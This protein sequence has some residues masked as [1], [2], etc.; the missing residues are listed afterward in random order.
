MT[1][2][3]A[4]KLEN[5][6]A[7]EKALKIIYAVFRVT[8]L[9][10]LMIIF[11]PPL[12]PARI[13]T[14]ITK[15][16]SLFTTTFSYN[17]ITDTLGRS[18]KLN[19]I[20]INTI[21][22]LMVSCAIIL[23]GVIAICAG[24]CLSLGNKT[25]KIKG[26]WFPIVGSILILAGLCGIY[27]SYIRVKNGIRPDKVP[28]NLSYS[29]Y[30]FIA[31][32][33]FNFILSITIRAL[34]RQDKKKQPFKIEQKY[35]LFLMFLPILILTF[36]FCYL[37]LY[38]WRYAFFD[39]TVGSDLTWK[40]F[41][42]F[43]WFTF[44]FK[45]KETF[46]DLLRVLRNTLIMSGL[47]ILTNWLPIAFAV[48]LVEIP[49]VKLKKTIQ[50]LTTLPYFIS[51]VL[52]YAFALALF[53]TDGLLNNMLSKITGTTHNTNYLQGDSWIWLKMLLWGTWKGIGWSAIVYIASLSSIDQQMYEA[54]DLDGA[55]RF[56]KINYITIP[57]LM[58]TY[59][60]LLMLQIAGMLSNGLDQY[61]VFGNA[62]NMDKIEV[63]D[64]YVY[65]LGF[66]KNNNM[67][68]I[69]TLVSMAKS[70]VSVILLF[71][72]NGASKLIRGE[73]IV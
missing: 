45:N 50:T 25:A 52:I 35:T 39:Y 2:T 7:K 64:L 57:M 29:Y 27:F 14:E 53:S 55:K 10:T 16:A 73:T 71:L 20:S 33:A 22:I 54:A 62:F 8:A 12:N 66:G 56:Q 34:L 43:Y 19:Y 23:I 5:L 72:A 15:H 32:A 40:N 30:L 49:S 69:S 1:D 60:V 37:P 13:T 42:G 4:L 21:Y 18:I 31:V 17:T 36:V 63:L 3:T 9:I 47:G 65:D 44:L 70:I 59:F 11:F 28:P 58:P 46:N 38:G 68:P 6:T 26:S 61:L 24:A 41:K 51:W 48:F 67:I